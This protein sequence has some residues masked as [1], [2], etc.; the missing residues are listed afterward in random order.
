MD[1]DDTILLRQWIH[2][3]DVDAFIQV[4]TRHKKMVYGV[5]FRILG[6][7]AEAETILQ[8]CFE[9][10][11]SLKNLPLERISGYLYKLAAQRALKQRL[12]K[13]SHPDEPY[14]LETLIDLPSEPGVSWNEVYRNT[15]EII[16]E[17][18][19]IHRDALVA[20]YFEQEPEEEIAQRLGLAR[21]SVSHRLQQGIETVRLGLKK[22][23][24]PITVATMGGWFEAQATALPIPLAHLAERITKV[25]LAFSAPSS[26]NNVLLKTEKRIPRAVWGGGLVFIILLCLIGLFMAP[27]HR[28]PAK[29]PSKTGQE[30]KKTTATPSPMSAVT[31]SA[32]T[33]STEKNSSEKSEPSPAKGATPAMADPLASLWGCWSAQ[34]KI[35]DAE[36]LSFSRVEFTKEG[37]LMVVSLE[38]RNSGHDLVGP[39]RGLSIQLGLR[40]PTEEQ[41][42]IAG[43][44]SPDAPTFE[45]K[46]TLQER[47][48]NLPVVVTLTRLS[49][50]ALLLEQRK[51]ELQQIYAA[52]SEYSK[53]FGGLYPDNLDDI[54]RF[55]KGD[56]SL[57]SSTSGRIIAYNG[58][59]PVKPSVTFSEDMLQTNGNVQY[60]DQLV[61][62]ETQLREG[63]FYD[64]LF[65]PALITITYTN[66][67]QQ[68]AVSTTGRIIVEGEDAQFSEAEA[69][70]R[71]AVCQNNLKQLGLVQKMFANEHHGFISAGWAMVYPEYLT[72]FT[73]LT[74]PCQPIGNN[75]YEI[76]FPG[77]LIEG[78]YDITGQ[79]KSGFCQ[80]L[81]AKVIGG[82]VEESLAQ[83][84]VPMVIERSSHTIKGKQGR[85]VLF[86][87][88][89]VELVPIGD[90][91]TKVDR[92]VNAN[93]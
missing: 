57:L 64:Y 6:H 18:S 11:A 30:N 1:M 91:A 52:L 17:L 78:T 51:N 16:L 3:R 67:R 49:G 87:D 66:P 37:N 80:D 62:A 24:I 33:Q 7:S 81:C 23:E 8:E 38:G 69:K 58:K 46:G 50:N 25:V 79:V 20:H 59:V 77:V 74:C 89:H 43:I 61:A 15:D 10:L 53:N 86:F 27:L 41:I 26:K 34:M 65:R 28:P 40:N 75:S 21:S 71:N 92:F 31:E 22:R 85:N 4:A 2:E 45:L 90:L 56:V 48:Q 35:N 54:K 47:D 88:G 73:I 29:S 68:I 12:S 36:T 55:F 83:S 60:A 76:L 19:D 63:G 9:T 14:R 42:T 39:I 70:Q 84:M 5:A 32:P 13:R 82:N 72:D 93:R 44:Y